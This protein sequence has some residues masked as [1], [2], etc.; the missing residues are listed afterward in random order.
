MLKHTCVLPCSTG[1]S[2]CLQHNISRRL[3]KATPPTCR[4]YQERLRTVDPIWNQK[5]E[6][7]PLGA[8]PDFDM[9]HMWVSDPR[10]PCMRVWG[11][12]AW[13]EH[14][15][16][17]HWCLHQTPDALVLLQA[18]EPA[19]RW[20]LSQTSDALVLVQAMGPAAGALRWCRPQ[21][22]DALIFTFTLTLTLTPLQAM[23]PAAGHNARAQPAPCNCAL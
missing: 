10:G 1:A 21:T 5:Y 6:T 11:G 19:L 16:A 8:V 12:A 7:K 4:S 22:F 9:L 17:L 15:C 18:V 13:R 2:H 14:K 3:H 23:G 20:C